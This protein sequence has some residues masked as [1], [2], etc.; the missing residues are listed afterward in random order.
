MQFISAV[1]EMSEWGWLNTKSQLSN[2]VCGGGGGD[3]QASF[4]SFYWWPGE[5]G[6]PLIDLSLL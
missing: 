5:T 6:A 4:L 3:G 1:P 2:V